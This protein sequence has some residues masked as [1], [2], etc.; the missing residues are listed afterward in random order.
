MGYTKVYLKLLKLLKDQHVIQEIIEQVKKFEKIVS[1]SDFERFKKELIK[2][3]KAKEFTSDFQII[4]Y[5]RIEDAVDLLG[6]DDQIQVIDYIFSDIKNNWMKDVIITEKCGYYFKRLIKIGIIKY[7]DEHLIPDGIN[8]RC[9]VISAFPGTGKTEL[10]RFMSINY[11]DFKIL[12]SDSSKFDKANFPANYIQ[13]IKD[14]M[15]EASIILV[16]SHE[17]V[18]TALVENNIDFE[19]IYPNKELKEEYLQRYHD[20][21][22]EESF[23]KLLSKNWDAWIDSCHE[24][25]NCNGLILSGI[26]NYLTDAVLDSLLFRYHRPIY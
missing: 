4:L 13:H 23:I 19:L 16:S 24:Q 10:C 17:A 25:K 11:P 1:D 5:D 7:V 2:S 22:N 20:R 15:E 12:D 18:R 14:N 9:E 21:G 3:V 26:G 8:K 6:F